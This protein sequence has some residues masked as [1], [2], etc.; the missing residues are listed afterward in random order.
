M[1]QTVPLAAELGPAQTGLTV[2]Y[3][4][5][6]V[7]GITI[8]TAWTSANV[9]ETAIPGT[10][11]VAGGVSVDDA[12]AYV[13]FRRTS[14]NVE[15]AFETIEPA[16][17]T[18]AQITSGIDSNSTQLSAILTDTNQLQADWADGGRLDLTLDSRA[19][20]SS[21]DAVDTV[22]GAI[23]ADTEGFDTLIADIWTYA[24][25]TLTSTAASTIS[26]LAGNTLNITRAVTYEATISGLNIPGTWSKLFITMDDNNALHLA[27]SSARVQIVVTNGGDAGD[28]LQYLNG[29]AATVGQAA[30]TV[31][32]AAGTVAIVIEDEATRSL[33]CGAHKYDIK[34]VKSDGRTQVLTAGDANVILTPTGAVS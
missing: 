27:D 34:I 12:G 24:S 19:S 2:E 7:D 22:V 26:A 14:D 30:L 1:A 31:D 10:Y 5:Y 3:Q 16:S 4:I 18:V 32:Q 8:D 28:G 13:V 21:L 23:L 25:R 9:A 33:D 6:E 17:P 29:A 11:R 15:L 20:Q